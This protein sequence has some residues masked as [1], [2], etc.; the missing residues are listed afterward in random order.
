MHGSLAIPG[1][2]LRLLLS[3][4]PPS[5]LLGL[6]R[7]DTE[8]FIRDQRVELFI[9][10]AP[11]PL[12]G[13]QET[14]LCVGAPARCD[15]FGVVQGGKAIHTIRELVHQLHVRFLEGYSR[16]EDHCSSM[17]LANSRTLPGH[18]SFKPVEALELIVWMRL[19]FAARTS[20][21]FVHQQAISSFDHAEEKPQLETHSTY[22]KDP[23]ERATAHFLGKDS[24]GSRDHT[25]IH[26]Q[27]LAPPRRSNSCPGAR[28]AAWSAS[29]EA[30][31]QLRQG[32]SCP[33]APL[34]TVPLSVRQHE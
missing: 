34:Q 22:S 6:S 32:R 30:I 13:R 18:G 14:H 15:S 26:F 25:H 9:P 8:F 28:A 11:P 23:H 16:R 5:Q 33:G 3:P 4:N 17:I 31:H 1:I 2:S 12:E 7:I 24:V 29:Q 19:P 10:E 20:E 27:R 21:R